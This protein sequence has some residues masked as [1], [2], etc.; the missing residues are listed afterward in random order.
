LT[1]TLAVAEQQA[2]LRVIVNWIDELDRAAT[3]T[4]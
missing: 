3:K 1:S 2:E 4:R